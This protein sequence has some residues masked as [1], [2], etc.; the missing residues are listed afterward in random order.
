MLGRLGKIATLAGGSWLASSWL[1]RCFQMGD[2][3]PSLL[4]RQGLGYFLLKG[5]FFSVPKT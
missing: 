4:Y 5:L 3:G 2:W 1:R